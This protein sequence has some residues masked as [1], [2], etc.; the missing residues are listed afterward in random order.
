V[1]DAVLSGLVQVL[2]PATL[3]LMLLGVGIG[4][5]VGVLPG[6][7]GAVTL[8][9]MLPFTF[10][11]EPVQGFAFLLGMWVVTATAG[12]MTS[13]LFGVP[14]EATSAAAV[15]DGYPLTRKG[16]GG[17]ALGAVL[18]SSTLGAVFGAIVLAFSVPVIRPLVLGRVSQ[19]A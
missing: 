8:A 18:S 14:G 2:E 11:M 19:P 12:D 7:G 15:L 3:G 13:V 4:F 6:L 9:L 17:R 10:G 1:L 16:Q 5:V